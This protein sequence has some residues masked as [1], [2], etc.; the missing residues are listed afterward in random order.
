MP[1][2]MTQI[3]AFAVIILILTIGSLMSSNNALIEQVVKAQNMT[4]NM[5]DLYLDNMSQFDDSG[6]I[7]SREPIACP[8]C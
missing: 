1:I 6:R 4:A 2:G 5:T 7:S 3:T 8:M